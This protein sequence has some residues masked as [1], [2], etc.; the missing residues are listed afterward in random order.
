MSDNKLDTTGFLGRSLIL[1]VVGAIV[2]K[3][4][5]FAAILPHRK[6]SLRLLYRR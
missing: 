4:L 3:V 6:F 5:Q 2:K 1:P